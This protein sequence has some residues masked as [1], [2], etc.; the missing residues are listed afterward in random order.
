MYAAT[1]TCIAGR[2][3]VVMFWG[4]VSPRLLAGLPRRLGAAGPLGSAGGAVWALLVDLE[5]GLPRLG[6]LPA[7][8][9][10]VSDLEG[11]RTEQDLYIYKIGKG[12]HICLQGKH[13][14]EDSFFLELQ[15]QS[16]VQWFFAA[17]M[18][19]YAWSGSKESSLYRKMQL[20]DR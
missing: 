12:D 17:C 13:A 3:L 11:R 16:A 4:T 7:T 8:S 14:H 10:I 2:A 5:G 1:L 15:L 6:F 19:K 9:C 20:K 18:C